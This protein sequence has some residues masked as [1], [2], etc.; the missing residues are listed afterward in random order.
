MI[1]NI[2][3]PTSTESQSFTDELRAG[4]RIFRLPSREHQLITVG[5][6]AARTPED[7]GPEIDLTGVP[8]A[9]TVSRQHA[10]LSLRE[11]DWHI[12]AHQDALNPTLLNGALLAP[13]TETFLKDGDMIQVGRVELGFRRVQNV[14]PE[15]I[16]AFIDNL[17]TEVIPGEPQQITLTLANH[18]GRVERFQ[19]A[20]VGLPPSWYRIILPD[21]TAGK[22]EVYLL[23]SPIGTAATPES[24]QYLRIVIQ[25]PRSF[26]SRAGSYNFE[27]IATTSGEPTLR[28]TARG[29]VKVTAFEQ[30]TLS[31]TPEEIHQP[32]GVYQ[33]SMHNLGNDTATVVLHPSGEGLVF[34]LD[35][36]GDAE[37]QL[38]P[39]ATAT[40][41]L[42]V[43][44][45]HRHWFGVEMP[46][47]FWASARTETFEPPPQRAMLMVPPRIP[48]WAQVIWTRFYA[49]L[50]PVIL[51]V[52][53]LVFAYLFL[54]PP[55]IL[56]FKAD[57]EAGRKL[58]LEIQIDRGCVNPE[59]AGPGEIK[60]NP[61][62]EDCSFFRRLMAA[63]PGV[64]Q[65]T[66]W[67]G[68][69]TLQPSPASYI[70]TVKNML[71]ISSSRNVSVPAALTPK[72]VSVRA[73]P[74]R[75]KRELEPVVLSWQ[76]Q[77]AHA[78]KLLRLDTPQGADPI[79]RDL[80]IPTSQ[81]AGTVTDTFELPNADY[82][83]LAAIVDEEAP[84]AA[85]E[86]IEIQCAAAVRDAIES[87]EACQKRKERQ[88]AAEQK[89]A[90]CKPKFLNKEVCDLPDVVMR[91][92][93]VAIDLPVITSFTAVPDT[94]NPEGAVQ[95]KGAVQNATQI[96]IDYR[97]LAANGPNGNGPPCVPDP[98]LPRTLPPGT[99]SID[100][101]VNPVCG[102]DFLV[103]ASNGGGTSTQAVSVKVTPIEIV[104]FTAQPSVIPTG[105]ETV[106]SWNVVGSA[107]LELVPGGA[108]APGETSRS[109]KPSGT[110][111]YT[112]TAYG[113]NRSGIPVSK[114]LVVT[115]GSPLVKIDL[116]S[117]TPAAIAP[118]GTTTLIL[119]V[120]SARRVTIK[121]SDGGVVL[122]QE[123]T[124][125]SV[126]RSVAVSPK[127]TTVYT[128]TV[129]NESG[130]ATAAVAVA[131]QAPPAGAAASESPAGNLR[132]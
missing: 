108:I 95:L 9:R 52:L 32:T 120:Q 69:G 30:L 7:H 112:L 128:L 78:V 16:E 22:P 115:V 59:L 130:Q 12:Q 3:E 29:V 85:K 131:V 94:I 96:V 6:R 66:R 89:F 121:G 82:L 14:G 65:P 58:T 57:V 18:T 13:G 100:V 20:I 48:G 88:A 47:H 125:A 80:H 28:G 97:P 50:A 15:S 118:G 61:E 72:I 102:A 26:E 56:T 17:E 98:R 54:R 116:F 64:A 126:Q 75:V 53:I 110:T 71:G 49:L 37:I 38:E 43:Q 63:F 104:A 92:V 33:A 70:V 34:G 1:L 91:I 123:V 122:D 62:P 84:T 113:P 10:S 8:G 41:E 2:N 19:V 81:L 129:S 31:L 21:G 106:L 5:R 23:H 39:G 119:S 90:Q 79:L 46:Y 35:E 68:T 105:G 27:V 109:V 73:D 127:E 107:L 114:K 60:L 44:P 77:D 42:A 101:T 132:R 99:S 67:T 51:L 87:K 25:P 76:T 117:A 74:D 83:I 111:E 40:V 103:K 124:Q 86:R 11:G 24:R 93:A 55:D 4:D 36:E 45:L